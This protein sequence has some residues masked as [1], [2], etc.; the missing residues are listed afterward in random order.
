MLKLTDENYCATIT[1]YKKL[2]TL[3]NCDNVVGTSFFGNQVIIPKTTDLNTL[4]VYFPAGCKLSSEFLRNNNLYRDSSLNIDGEKKGYFETNGRVKAMLFRK[5]ESSGMW[6]PIECLAY[7]G[8]DLSF[9]KE[10]ERFNFVGNDEIASKYIP[11]AGSKAS[12]ASSSL[13]KM[14][15]DESQFALHHKTKHLAENI[16]E[17]QMDSVLS[18]TIKIHGTS[19]VAARLLTTRKYTFIEKIK[20]FFNLKVN[21]FR[22]R[23]VTSSRGVIKD[24]LKTIDGYD[25]WIDNTNKIADSIAEGVTVYGEIFGAY[26]DGKLIQKNYDYDFLFKSGKQNAFAVYRVTYTTP[27]GKVFEYNWN[28]LQ[29]Y[30][31][32]KG[33]EAVPLR[34]YGLATEL[35]EQL[36]GRKPET[37][38]E[39]REMLINGLKAEIEVMEPFCKNVVPREGYCIRI[40]NVD[41]PRAFKLKSFLFKKYEDEQLDAGE[42]D[43]ETEQSL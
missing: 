38:E 3:K 8:L 20:R 42:L 17:I 16:A 10:N 14:G 6:M 24:P 40:E 30:C 39:M 7:T 4:G 35:A 33:L 31:N 12:N 32:K 34:Y 29:N 28:D 43:I 23:L 36:S 25:L 9:L 5:H 37:V 15:I 11:V 2:I 19:A 21:P 18:V 22:Y 41:K 26:P 13:S 1:R 27:S